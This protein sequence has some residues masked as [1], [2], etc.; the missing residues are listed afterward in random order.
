[1]EWWQEEKGSTYEV[2]A[3]LPSVEEKQCWKVLGEASKLE[4]FIVY[5]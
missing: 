5:F 1:M 4:A 2:P 3:A